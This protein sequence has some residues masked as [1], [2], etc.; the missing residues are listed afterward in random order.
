MRIRAGSYA[1]VQNEGDENFAWVSTFVWVSNPIAGFT[2]V[3]QCRNA[4]GGILRS[5]CIQ[6]YIR[7]EPRQDMSMS[8]CVQV[9]VHTWT[10]A[11]KRAS[12]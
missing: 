11:H 12:I 8:T 10:N 3:Q 6:I 5:P 7:I 4:G 1:S 2:I 9:Y